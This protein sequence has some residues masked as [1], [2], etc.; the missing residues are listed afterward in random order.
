MK[1]INVIGT[2][3]SGKTTFSKRLATQ[4]HLNYIELDNLFWL[5]DWIESP[6]QLFLEK[7]QQQLDAH[8]QGWVIDGNYN[9]RTAK[10]KW[11]QV[12]TIIWIDLPF[13]LNL[14]QSVSRTL[15]R[16][17]TQKKL[18]S[19]SNNKES[20]NMMLSRESIILW[21]IKTHKKNRQ[22]YLALMSHSDYQHIQFIH[23]RSRSE[24]QAFFK[25]IQ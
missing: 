21:M 15:Y 12:D 6:D 22:K 16:L 23:L 20:L 24:V 10:L 14:Y 4:L 3:G 2:S 1:Y 5:D 7:I 13:Y 19:N 18:W 25:N 9:G 11:K 17:I 8:P